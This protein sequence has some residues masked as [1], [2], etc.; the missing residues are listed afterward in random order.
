MAASRTKLSVSGLRRELVRAA[1]CEYFGLGSARA[2]VL[3]ALYERRGA[4]ARPTGTDLGASIDSHRRPTTHALEESICLLRACLETE[5]IDFADGGYFLTEA[6]LAEC[7]D[8][9]K[10]IGELLMR[11]GKLAA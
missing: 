6:G 7:D 8:A 10:H 1:F 11:A 3:I 2:E 4:P 5:T 9:L